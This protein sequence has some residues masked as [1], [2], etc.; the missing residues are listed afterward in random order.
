MAHEHSGGSAHKAIRDLLDWAY[1][2]SDDDHRWLFTHPHDDLPRCC[3]SHVHELRAR[4]DGQTARWIDQCVRLYGL[5]G[6]AH[7]LDA[8]CRAAVAL[9]AADDVFASVEAGMS[10]PKRSADLYYDLGIFSKPRLISS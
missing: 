1:D 2:A 6:P 3:D 9:D 8:V 7:L 5:D 4:I 10:L